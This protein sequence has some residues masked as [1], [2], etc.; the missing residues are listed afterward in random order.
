MKTT[1]FDMIC[2]GQSSIDTIQNDLG[3]A[4]NI[5]GGAAIY[6]SVVASSIGA[7]V[8]LVS[9]IG[10]DFNPS[11]LEFIQQTGV[12]IQG[13]M[14]STGKSTKI[15]LV[16]RGEDLSSI[17]V[18]EGVADDMTA[19]DFPSEYF[20]TRLVHFTTLP[21][22]V[23]LELQSLLKKRCVISYD[24]HAEL[25]SMDLPSIKALLHDVD[26][27]ICNMHELLRITKARNAADAIQKITT[28]GPN[29]FC[30]MNGSKGASII[31]EDETFTIPP[32]PP[33]RIVDFVGAGD[34]F[35]AGFLFSYVQGR[36]L[37]QSGLIGALCASRVIGGFGL[38]CL[39]TKEYITRALDKKRELKR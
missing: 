23:Q 13:V 5:L 3:T 10:D 24:P 20:Q 19:S 17:K 12:D 35:A 25:N 30:L 18:C 29:L 6:P 38:S 7:K 2:V 27:L 14:R 28:F 31:S 4:E 16:Y 1:K 22:H 36:S 39:P 33:H 11:F 8:G 15:R 26:I 34:A 37:F 9:R 21:Y 32:I